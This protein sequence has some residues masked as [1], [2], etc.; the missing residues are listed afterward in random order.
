VSRSSCT[1]VEV[2]VVQSCT[3]CTCAT[4]AQ[5]QRCTS[6]CARALLGGSRLRCVGS[7]CVSARA[8]NSLQQYTIQVAPQAVL[9]C[10][11]LQRRIN[12]I[13]DAVVNC[14]SSRR[15]SAS[16]RQIQPTTNGESAQHNSCR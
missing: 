2:Q 7:Q 13:G 12:S 5:L 4:S 1:S 14:T 6:S 11:T 3:H 9:R 8:S 16:S 10:A 15:Q